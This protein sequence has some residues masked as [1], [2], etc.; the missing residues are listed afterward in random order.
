MAKHNKTIPPSR[1]A[2]PICL[3]IFSHL[4]KGGL[5]IVATF[6]AVGQ[7]PQVADCSTSLYA[8]RVECLKGAVQATGTAGGHDLRAEDRTS[9]VS[10]VFLYLMIQ[11]GHEFF[12]SY[13][14]GGGVG[15]PA[16]C[17]R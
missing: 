9:Q 14:K 7:L 6:V 10:K 16:V 2:V 13:K 12:V 4:H 11:L 17:D 5:K 3:Q 1:Q 8:L 15:I